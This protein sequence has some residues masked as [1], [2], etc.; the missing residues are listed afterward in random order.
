MND[1]KD[2]HRESRRSFLAG[3]ALL[4]TGLL[5]SGPKVLAGQNNEGRSAVLNGKRSDAAY[6]LV[7]PINMI[8]SVCLQCNTGCGITCKQQ[9]GVITKIDGNPYNPWTLLPHLPYST[10]P[11]DAAPVDGSICPKGQAGLQTAYDPYRLRKVLKRAGKRGENKWV[12][13][14]F[15][16]AVQEICDGGKLFAEVPGEENR[17]VE[18][19]KKLRALTDPKISKEMAGDVKNILDEKDKVKKKALV[20]EFKSKHATDLDKLIDPNHPDLGP[21]NNQIVLA[22]GRLKGGRAELYK[23]LAEGLGTTNAHGHT[24]VCQGSLYFT[25][26]AI[27]EQYVD[28]KF[29]DGKKFYWQADLENS[30]F[31][32]FVGANLF[33]GNYGPPNRAVRLT[34]NLVSGYTKIAVADP[35][36]SKLA[37]KA[38]KWLPI[39]PGTDAALAAGMI[40]WILENKRFDARFLSC[41]NKAAAVIAG[42]NSWSN[43]TWL[44]EIKDGKPG[45]FV[46][47][48]DVGLAQPEVRKTKAGKEYQEKFVLVMVQGK[49]VA[50][51]PNDAKTPVNGDL[52]VDTTL[53]DGTMVKSSLQVL[54]ES[55]KQRTLREWADISG[56]KESDMI[57]VARELTSY[58]KRAAVDIHRGPA[59]HTNGFY[60]VLSWMTVNMLL[61]NF[62]AKGGMIAAST[63]DYMGKGKLY[64]LASNPRKTAS[65]GISSIRHGV[66]YEK[67][68]IFSGYPAKRNWYP[69]SSDIYE[70]IVPSIG[71]AYPYPAKAL[72]LYMGAPTYSL[73]A[74]H[75]NIKILCDTEKIPLFIAN[76]I[77]IGTTSMYADYIFP[78]LSHLERWEFQGSHP[79]VPNKVQPVRQPAMAPIPEECTVYGQK[80]P[81]SFESMILGIAERLELPGFGE[82]AFGKGID[83][84]HPDDFYLRAA[85]NL[86]FGEKPDGSAAVPDAEET[87]MQ[88]FREARRYLPTSVYDEARWKKI[89]GEKNWPKV[90]YVLN[91]GGRFE[92]WVKG[93]KDDR[94]AHPYGKLLNMYQEKTSSTV[95][96]G[97]GKKNLGYAA[98][99]PIMDYHGK[100]PEALRKGHDFAMITHRTIS[101]CKSRTVADPWLTPIMPENGFLVN[102]EDAKRLGLKNGDL[103]KVV[104]ASN[105]SGEWDLGAGNKKLMVGKVIFTQTVRPGVMSFALGFGHWATGAA[106]VTVD[107]HLIKGEP[108]RVAG[109]H[110]NAAMWVDP[111]LKNT[112]MLDPV[113]GSVS[114]YDT[115]VRLVPA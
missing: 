81:M 96:S 91:R 3:G 92:D 59:Q 51:D 110:A 104:S 66:D 105:P 44:V 10:H 20:E 77:L 113:G 40:Q 29:A 87:E 93:Y 65:F 38:W 24:T 46:R 75:T 32:F 45:K 107:G 54:L 4:G 42:E 58:G 39:K 49:P 31:V 86:A 83:L 27:S 26:K 14:P 50:I 37:S 12:S 111:A 69:L 28:G 62:D 19:L 89:A 95:H 21:R 115:H 112:C 47:A 34:G 101:Q 102:P 15:D 6:E 1:T 61:G 33:E 100:E 70:E 76:D 71:D 17:Q 85:A 43:A 35:R 23:R 79:C 60:N 94:V 84:K 8:Y 64:E 2:N 97:T 48:A 67:T 98:Y 106:D 88:I 72:F 7:K 68:T 63:Y 80:M 55:S 78:D 22:W 13:I 109:V 9:N 108:R 56:V 53:P 52:F 114:F 18:G 30:R 82:D 16:Q 74:G 73:P 11:R 57:A 99:I 103:A 41:A 25:C 90:V 5:V 36:F